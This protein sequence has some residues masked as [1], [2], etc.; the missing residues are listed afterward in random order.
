MF[1]SIQHNLPTTQTYKQTLDKLASC[2][3]AGVTMHMYRVRTGHVQDPLWTYLG[4][5]LNMF[6]IHFGH[7]QVP[8]GHVQGPL[9]T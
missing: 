3:H 4:S 9:W 2:I 6:R 8:L 5:A 1:S 7:V